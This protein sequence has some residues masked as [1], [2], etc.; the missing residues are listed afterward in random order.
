MRNKNLLQPVLFSLLLIA[1]LVALKASAPIKNKA[2]PVEN[3]CCSKSKT[4]T[5][6]RDANVPAHLFL[7]NLSNQFITVPLLMR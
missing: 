5:Q 1:C 2:L 3:S 6:K 4:C 7:D